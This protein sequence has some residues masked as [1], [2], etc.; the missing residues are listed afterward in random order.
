MPRPKILPGY[1]VGHLTVV[2][3][4]EERKNGYMVWR[5]RCDCG[6]EVLLDTRYLQRGTIQDC[7]CRTKLRPGQRDIA[8]M[9]FGKLVAV[10]PVEGGGYG[11]TLWRCQ[12]DCGGEVVSS[13]HQL[14]AGYRKSCGCLSHPP[15]EDLVGQKF[16]MLT[17]TGYA[18]KRDNRV[19]YWNCVCEC[20]NTTTV[21]QD[22]LKSGKTQ[23]CGCLS[24][25]MLKEKMRFIDGTSVT[26]L[27]SV[28]DKRR[29]NNKS[30]YTGVYQDTKHQLWH[31][32][33]TFKGQA[34]DLGTYKTRKEAIKAR[35]RGEEIHE[36]FLDWYY[37]NYSQREKT[38]ETLEALSAGD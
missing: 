14:T 16:G 17:V 29:S 13:L 3:K 6:N 31:A 24:R 19:H 15:L 38:V 37:A 33:I 26:M 2:E 25:K 30:G 5:C 21:R 20:G 27:E 28:R 36:D 18:E 7:G 23:S 34:Y 1:Q 10:E 12:C 32:R 9:R 11:E 4:T 35:M 22:F 8:G